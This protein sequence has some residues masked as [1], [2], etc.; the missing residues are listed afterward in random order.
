MDFIVVERSIR[1]FLAM[2]PC[3]YRFTAAF[4]EWFL[5]VS[6]FTYE[7]GTEITEKLGN[8][9]TIKY[10]FQFAQYQIRFHEI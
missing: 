4:G 1:A 5:E 9:I 2:D 6:F 3:N 10:V 8:A 7:W